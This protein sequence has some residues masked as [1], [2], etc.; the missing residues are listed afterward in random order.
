[1]KLYTDFHQFAAA[2]GDYVNRVS[3]PCVS[4]VHYD[5]SG[6]VTLATQGVVVALLPCDVKELAAWLKQQGA[7]GA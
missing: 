3:R 2:A 6:V 1:M 4:H 5:D 7:V